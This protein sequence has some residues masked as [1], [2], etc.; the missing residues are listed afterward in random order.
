MKKLLGIIALVAIAAV[1]GWNF[2]QNQN[3]VELSD[4]ALANVTALANGESGSGTIYCCGNYGV[5][6]K[7]IDSQG[8]PHDVAG[9]RSSHPCP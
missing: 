9:I 2:S 6:M 1:V 8:K 5:C 4:L 7:V 3:G